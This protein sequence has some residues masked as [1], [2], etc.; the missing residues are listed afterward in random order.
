ML[1]KVIKR[2]QVEVETDWLYIWKA[3]TTSSLLQVYPP[4]SPTSSSVSQ[5][6]DTYQQQKQTLQCNIHFLIKDQSPKFKM[7]YTCL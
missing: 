5:H 7:H 1:N 3:L 4:L 2:F 6:N